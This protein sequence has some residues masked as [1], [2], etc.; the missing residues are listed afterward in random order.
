MNLDQILELF[1]NHSLQGLL[2]A[3]GAIIFWV[4]DNVFGFP[5]LIARLFN[6]IFQ[7][8]LQKKME[9]MESHHKTISESDII[10]HKIFNHINFLMYN[11]IPTF[12]FSS[13][14]RTAVFRKYLTI[15]LKKHK[16]VLKKFVESKTFE[17]ID[18][19]QLWNTFLSLTNEI[20][21]DYETEMISTGIPKIIVEKMKSKN[22]DG[23]IYTLTLI[24]R[25]CESSFHTS[26]KN[27][28]KVLTILDIYKTALETT[29]INSVKV[30]NSIN[31]QLKGLSID[32]KTEP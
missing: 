29:M 18:D 31:G 7:I 6:S 32:G 26:D 13:E 16:D 9:E 17:H 30:C 14:F 22:N 5:R 2:L 15:Y 28:L 11:K 23:L 25:I 3:V 12:E 8:V 21:F 19:A 10:K 24:E 4:L 20:I 27:F 1:S